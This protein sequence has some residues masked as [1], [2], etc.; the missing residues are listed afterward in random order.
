MSNP[1][2]ILNHNRARNLNLDRNLSGAVAN[3]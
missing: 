3:A 1:P 2:H